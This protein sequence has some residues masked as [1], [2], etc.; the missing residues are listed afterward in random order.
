VRIGNETI[1]Q[2]K[3]RRKDSQRRRPLGS[4]GRPAR[5]SAKPEITPAKQTRAAKPR[6][7]TG[8][9]CSAINSLPDT[10]SNPQTELSSQPAQRADRS[11]QRAPQ[12][13]QTSQP[14]PQVEQTSQPAPQEQPVRLT[15]STEPHAA[16]TVSISP[17]NQTRARAAGAAGI[18]PGALRRSTPQ[19]GGGR[20]SPGTTAPLKLSTLLKGATHPRTA[21]PAARRGP[22]WQCTSVR[23]R[24]RGN[25]AAPPRPDPVRPDR[26]G[27]Q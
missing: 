1:A 18:A 20:R 21:S 22:P 15:S 2:L 5:P 9:V 6:R 25:I 12:A 11:A 27:P 13:E 16:G 4:P 10:A 19:A 3:R 23:I 17:T 8:L 24:L 7:S 26:P 14:A